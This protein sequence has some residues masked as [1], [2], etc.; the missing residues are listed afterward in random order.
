MAV[1]FNVKVVNTSDTSFSLNVPMR[2]TREFNVNIG[3]TF[4]K[5]NGLGEM[6]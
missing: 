5:D 1:E 2:S 4:D 3:I 6:A